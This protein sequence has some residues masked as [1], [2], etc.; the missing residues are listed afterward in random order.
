MMSSSRWPRLVAVSVFAVAAA[1]CDVGMARVHEPQALIAPKGRAVLIVL[2]RPDSYKSAP[3]LDER[4]SCLGYSHS[5]SWFAVRIAPGEQVIHM[6]DADH[7][8]SVKI[9]V[10]AGKTYF[11]RAGE[12]GSGLDLTP[13][14]PGDPEWKKLDA[15]LASADQYSVDRKQCNSTLS[16]M[17]WM[18]GQDLPKLLAQGKKNANATGLLLRADDG[19][20]WRGSAKKSVR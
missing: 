13:V 5:N 11:L 9:D 14:R 17:T 7:L 1:S 16:D 3:I 6:K 20:A 15:F 4:G 8:L 2:E 12:K 18:P 10:E 19:V